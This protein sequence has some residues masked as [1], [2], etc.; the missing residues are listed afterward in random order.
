MTTTI[1]TKRYIE[2][3][4][5]QNL[6][7]QHQ[8]SLKKIKQYQ[9]Q[10]LSWDNTS[11]YLYKNLSM[12]AVSVFLGTAPIIASFLSPFLKIMTVGMLRIPYWVAIDA[13]S[14]VF[15][16]QHFSFPAYCLASSSII[17]W[18]I[19]HG[20]HHGAQN[21]TSTGR[22]PS[23]TSDFHVESV[24]AGTAFERRVFLDQFPGMGK[25][26]PTWSQRCTLSFCK[27]W[28]HIKN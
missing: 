9:N 14:S 26:I 22:S 23:R 6:S 24:T 8:Y 28:N 21:S 17:G 11:P 18:I 2:K 5:A 3:R 16:L 20:P 10:P 27:H 25:K 7:P 15:S 19:R 1:H 4:T 13:L 12:H